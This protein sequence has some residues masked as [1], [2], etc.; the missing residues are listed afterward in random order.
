MPLLIASIAG[1]LLQIASSLAGRVFL[2]L[3]FSYL[4]FTGLDAGLSTIEQLVMS[5]MGGVSGDAVAF[6]AWMNLDK[7]LS[8]IFSAMTSA[9]ALKGITGG[10]LTKIITK[11]PS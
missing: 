2:A 7:A 10:K 1:A 11:V 3:G 5:K 4:T 8:M 9:V 6:F